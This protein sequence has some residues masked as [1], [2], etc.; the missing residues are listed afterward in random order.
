MNDMR[1]VQIEMKIV[2]HTQNKMCQ[3]KDQ[4]LSSEIFTKMVH[5]YFQHLQ[6]TNSILIEQ[7]GLNT[8]QAEASAR[9]AVLLRMLEET[10][11]EQLSNILPYAK[12]FLSRKKALHKFVEGLYDYWRHFDRFMICHSEQ[13]LNGHDRKPYRTFN[14]TIEKLSHLVRAVYRDI[15]ENITG[16]HP[17]VYRQVHAGCNV[18]IIAV[19]KKW[20]P[21]NE[22]KDLLTDIPF[23]RQLLINPPF[24][25]N[26]PMNKRTGQFQKVNENPLIGMTLNK[27]EWLCYPAQIG[28]LTIFVYFHQNFLELGCSLANLFELATDDQI[29]SGPDAIYLFGA[30]PE[31][32]QK[33]GDLPTVFHDDEKNNLTV[34]AVPSESRFGYFGYLKKMVLTLHN[35]VMMRRGRM[36]F[37]GAMSLVTLKGGGSANVLLIGDTAAGKSETLEAFRIMGEEYI[38][39]LT[40]IA[41]DMGS[42]EISQN[43]K[44]IGYGTEIGAFIRL[45]DLQQGYA[46]GQI[47]RS[48]I[49]SPHKINARIVLPVTTIEEVLEG[50][51][52]DFLLYANNYEEVDDKHPAIEQFTDAETACHVFQEGTVLAKGTTTST[53]LVHS[54]FAN[55]F[56]PPQY[57]E[58]HEKLATETMKAAF[59]GNIYVGQMRTQ[60]GIPGYESSGPEEAARELF[61][62]IKNHTQKGQ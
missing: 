32:M 24:I 33:Y 29:T 44:I 2:L 48:I 38:R 20:Q 58:V 55:I 13:G 52:I 40:I 36:P 9:L 37:H 59:K 41:D 17:R 56:G 14:E 3:T 62:L 42:I 19:D 45:D 10:T 39:N 46:F 21:P 54:Y 61:A 49:M 6:K 5:L 1:F 51:P 26:P 23:I 4:L 22:Y 60:L 30:P 53:G 43:G 47:D 34:A 50:Y 57:K 15:C 27:Q 16:D 12:D 25:I 18:G 8:K 31:H 11:L 28:P 35:I 7:L